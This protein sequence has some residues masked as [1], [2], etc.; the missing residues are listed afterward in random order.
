MLLLKCHKIYYK[1]RDIYLKRY[2]ESY[3]SSMGCCKQKV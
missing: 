1:Q 3:K 2:F